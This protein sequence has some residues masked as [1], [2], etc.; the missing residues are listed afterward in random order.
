M[1]IKTKDQDFAISKQLHIKAAHDAKFSEVIDHVTNI[2]YI[3]A[4]CK[5]N[6][7]KTMFQEACATAHDIKS[8]V[9]GSHYFLLCEW[10]DMTPISTK[11]TDINEV[12]M[13]RKAKRMN[14]NVRQAYSRSS[15]RKAKRTNYVKF[16]KEHPL[17]L[18]VF[19]RFLSHIKRLLKS[20]IPA[21][22]DVLTKG[23]F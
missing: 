18:E 4:E 22:L 2:G 13:L 8:A 5:T 14:S 20:E 11:S 3:V 10:L 23:Y 15:N 19:Q 17:Q 21:E 9:T 6:L 16:L 1:T 12:L 7:D